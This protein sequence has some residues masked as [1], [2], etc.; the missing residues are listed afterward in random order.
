[1]PEQLHVTAAAL[2]AVLGC[3]A[4]TPLDLGEETG[5]GGAP[6]TTISTTTSSATTSTTTASTTTVSSSTVS[7]TTSSMMGCAPGEVQACYTGPAQ[8]LGVG[9]CSEGIETCDDEG[10]LGPCLGDTTP[11]TEVCNQLDDDCD[12]AVDERGCAVV[13]GCA[14]GTREGFV[15]PSAFPDVAG[16]AGGFQVPGILGPG[17]PACG[18]LA[19]DDSANPGGAGCS[20][21]DLC[22]AG[23]HVCRSSAE[24][25]S[26]SAGGCAG[27]TSEPG[28]F[29]VTRQSG[30]GCGICALGSSVSPACGNCEC[31]SD[32]LQNDLTA[33]D[34]F[35]CGT[36]GASTSSCG[37]FDRFSNNMCSS[38]PAP[39]SCGADGCNEAHALVKPGPGAGGVLCC[40]T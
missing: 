2:C 9:E 20:A 3:G 23:F 19:G 5:A 1:M 34:L 40:R 33:N 4:R 13:E 28:L 39:W 37:A 24:L 27:I 32:C 38:L 25:L 10:E 22:G 17:V 31:V 35:G 29:F 14:D 16:C 36:A 7:S 8:T 11:S 26:L 15:D 21:A 18:S 6:P 12:G 30:P